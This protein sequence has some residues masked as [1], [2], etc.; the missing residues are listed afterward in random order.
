[1]ANKEYAVSGA[2]LSCSQGTIPTPF[3][4]TMGLMRTINGMAMGTEGDKIPF[5][6]IKPF[7]IC[8]IL[9]KSVLVPCVPSPT[10]WQ[11][12]QQWR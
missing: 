8:Q 12:N 6:N 4:S 7:G 2:L 9:T 10:F 11:K 5:A 3:T 1:M